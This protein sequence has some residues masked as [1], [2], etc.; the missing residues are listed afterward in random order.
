MR[1]LYTVT[2]DNDHTLVEEVLDSD[3]DQ[4]ILAAAR[5]IFGYMDSLFEGG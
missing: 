2:Q 5:Q 3:T 4:I 1:D